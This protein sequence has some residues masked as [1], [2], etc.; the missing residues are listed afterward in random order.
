[1]SIRFTQ[2]ALKALSLRP[3]QKKLSVTD[4]DQSGLSFELH[5]SGGY[6]H[7]R[8]QFEGRQ[9]SITIGHFGTITIAD[10]RQKAAEYARQVAL[11][12]DPQAAKQVRR[13][14]PLYGDFIRDQYLPFIRTNKR[15]YDTDVSVLNNHLLPAFGN[16]KLI[17]I[18]HADVM[19]F[20]QAKHAAGYTPGTMN[21]ML[22]LL[23]Y[24]FNLAA[25]WKVPGVTDNPARAVKPYK[26]NNKIE[27]YLSDEEAL[28]LRDALF[29]SRNQMLPMI[30][31]FLLLT[32]ARKREVLDAR[33]EQIDL[34]TGIWRIPLSKSGKAR[35]V[36]LSDAAIQM[37]GM[38]REQLGKLIGVE[39]TSRCAWIFPNP[40]TR[41]PYNSIFYAWDRVRRISSLQD[42]RIHD[43]RHT[44]ASTLVN[45]GVPIYEVQK[46]L[47]HQHIR[48]TERYAHLAPER[49]KMSVTVAGERFGTLLDLP[50]QPLVPQRLPIP[51]VIEQVIAPND[52]GHEQHRAEVECRTMSR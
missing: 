37:L 18:S 14:S 3:G 8:Y 29:Q 9:R 23:R 17:H 35:H 38:A 1:M 16:R 15:S 22:V 32:G 42:V 6:F 47:G 33:W 52:P 7:Y 30:V 49:L 10:A 46:V 41:Q 11:G 13:D 39:T 43:L 50:V 34:S 4:S 12:D 45:Q 28:R 5:P 44:F 2:A 19:Q 20:L 36:P 21:R 27:R 24:T 31:A 25:S 51:A 40:A 26:E 48:T